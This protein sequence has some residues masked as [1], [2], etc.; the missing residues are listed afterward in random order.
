MQAEVVLDNADGRLMPGMFCHASLKVADRPDA[1]TIP[2]SAIYARGGETWVLIADG[3]AARRAD[4]VVGLDAGRVVA[5]LSGLEGTERV[6]L[7][8]PTGLSHGDPIDAGRTSG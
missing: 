6:I 8:R 5:I 4:V 7:G 2:G 3:G 1:I